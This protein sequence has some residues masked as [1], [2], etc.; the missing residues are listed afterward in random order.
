MPDISTA[1]GALVGVLLAH[2]LLALYRRYRRE[3]LKRRIRGI[4]AG[5]GRRASGGVLPER[6]PEEEWG[7]WQESE[8]HPGM[9][10]RVHRTDEEIL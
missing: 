7:P 6:I 3:R 4:L 10:L 9:R 2:A 8:T 1:L 5:H